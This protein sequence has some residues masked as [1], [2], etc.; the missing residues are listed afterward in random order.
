MAFLGIGTQ[1]DVIYSYYSERVR[2]CGTWLV[3]AM[4]CCIAWTHRTELWT[5]ANHQHCAYWKSAQA[6]LRAYCTV[7]GRLDKVY[8]C[9]RP[10]SPRLLKDI[11]IEPIVL[12]V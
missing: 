8:V 9:T 3:M 5:T 4:D 7:Q 1:A 12:L 6:Q 11:S 2:H 10:D